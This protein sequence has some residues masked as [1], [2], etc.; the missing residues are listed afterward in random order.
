MAHIVVYCACGSPAVSACAGC[1]TKFYCSQGCQAADWGGGHKRTCSPEVVREHMRATGRT[2]VHIC[3][4]VDATESLELMLRFGL[5]TEERDSTGFTPL[6]VA[7]Q[8]GKVR[9]LACLLDGGAQIDATRVSGNATAS[10]LT[11]AFFR[12]STNFEEGW[13]CCRLLL[14]RGA[15]IAA[16]AV[17]VQGS[18]ILAAVPHLLP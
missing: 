8:S 18:A 3:A 13:A 2:P 1:Y 9:A 7:A 5:R 11:F 12:I 15:S 10:A 16:A 4:A 14:S 17:G 6:M